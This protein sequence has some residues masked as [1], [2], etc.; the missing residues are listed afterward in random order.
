MKKIEPTLERAIAR[1]EP[2]LAVITGGIELPQD[3]EDEIDLRVPAVTYTQT[4]VLEVRPEVMQRNRLIAPTDAGAALNAFKLLRTQL[5]QI[6]DRNDWCA[7]GVTSPGPGA[8]K[9]L[10]AINLAI[11]LALDVN[12]T[13]LLVDLDLRRPSVH[14]YFGLEDTRGLGDYLTGGSDLRGLLFNPG[15]ERL[16]VL[17]GGAPRENSSELLTS[18]RMIELAR[19][20]KARYR[21]R[22]VLF[23]LPPLFAG[24][25]AL[26][27]SPRLDAVLMVAEE[28]RTKK[29]E[30]EAAVALLGAVPIIGPVLNKARMKTAP[31]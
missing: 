5:L 29:R 8:G 1:D 28:G 7:L 15:I 12:H 2:E 10:T 9:T 13:V 14:R 11:S 24:D 25:D 30:I 20:M 27:F 17:P 16:V 3:N 21:S 4:R 26:A 23:D 31:Y 22:I 18:P 19:E 6:M